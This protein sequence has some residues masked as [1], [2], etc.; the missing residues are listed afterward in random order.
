[1]PNLSV[2]VPVYNI[3]K[4]IARCIE[5]II[6]QSFCDFEL[7]L[8]DDGSTDASGDICD[9][10]ARMDCRVKVF[11]QNNRGLVSARKKGLA[12]ASGKYIANVDGDDWIDATLFEDAIGVLEKE[13]TDY[14]QF[15]YYEQYEDRAEIISFP[16]IKTIGIK[17]TDDILTEWF[18]KGSASGFGS[19]VVTKVC[20]TDIFRVAYGNVPDNMNNGEDFFFFL[21]LLHAA[22]SFSSM[23]SSYYHYRIRNDSLSHKTGIDLLL[24][25]NVLTQ[26]FS[27][28]VKK[29]ELSDLNPALEAWKVRRTF[30]N[31]NKMMN[32]WFGND[33]SMAKYVF[34]IIPT[35][36][37]KDIIIY[38]AGT[39]GKELYLRLLLCDDV[40]VI[41]WVDANYRGKQL[42]CEIETVST[43]KEKV[44]DLVVV[45]I[46]N[47]NTYRSIRQELLNMG[48]S[49][50]KIVWAH[51]I[52][53]V[54]KCLEMN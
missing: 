38:G 34:D 9:Q 44:F 2:V 25:E 31:F 17:N 21:Y 24:K 18:E 10:Y 42:S 6:E 4:Y 16:E 52:T 28:E 46:K 50:E 20:R 51:P 48:I 33:F 29:F 54:E 19:Q 23:S 7:I 41:A 3:E 36:R 22:S 11:H 13:R 8:V 1:M 53:L 47:E 37:N 32:S 43:L 39:V 49:E 45:A 12:L 26:Y 35:I 5:S 40:R 15:G 30:V 14:I 27:E